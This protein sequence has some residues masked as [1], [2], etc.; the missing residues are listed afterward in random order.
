MGFEAAHAPVC[1]GFATEKSLWRFAGG[2][3]H[4]GLSLEARHTMPESAILPERFEE[5][6]GLFEE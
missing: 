1:R 5:C 4:N 3:A 2:R 6:P